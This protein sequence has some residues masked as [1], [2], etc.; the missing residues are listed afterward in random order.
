M[1]KLS[2]TD[3]RRILRL[4][5]P[6]W[7]ILSLATLALFFGAAISLIYPQV[8]RITVDGFFERFGDVNMSLL[9]LAAITIF[10]TQAF[11]TAMR[12]F[13][14]TIVGDRIVT[15]LR[16]QLYE[17]ILNQEIGFFDSAQIGELTS[18]LNSDTQVLQNAV[19]SN[20]SMAL[21]FG[22]QVIAGVT[23]LFW[24]APK[25]AAVMIIAVPIVVFS[26]VY[27]GQKV[28][29]L[30]KVVQTRLAEATAIADESIGGIRTVRSFDREKQEIDRYGNAIELSFQ[31]AKQRAKLRALFSGSMSFLGYATVGIILWYGAVLVFN[32]E[33]TPG[34]LTAFVLYTLMIA[35]AL[36][37]LTSLWSDFMRAVGSAERVFE[38]IDRPNTMPSSPTPSTHPIDGKIKF[39]N[40]SFAYPTR[41][42]LNALKTASFEIQRGEKIALIG[43]SGSGKST[44]ANLILR[45][46]DPQ[47]GKLLID[48]INLPDFDIHHL[49]SAIGI[50]AQEPI[51][52]SGTIH[53]NV[54]YGRI[55]ATEHQIRDALKDANALNFVEE[56]P[57]GLMTT[58]GE[59]GIRLSGGQKQRIAIARAILKDPRILILD[60][61]TSALDIESESLVQEALER[62][63]KNRT[64][65]IIAHR[66]ST[67]AIADRIIV[68][69]NGEVKELGTHQELINDKGAYYDLI[70]RYNL[71]GEI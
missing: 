66:L 17:S 69:A 48:G 44:I 60:E 49:R 31:T 25:L 56:F 9:I 34:E 7:K 59:R 67:I 53:D 57:E 41:P 38:L 12:Y 10:L 11:F 5:I 71:F 42:K 22:L 15:D 54:L 46:Y 2:S 4:A 13:L 16:K 28:R 21:R 68:L 50:V 36:G 24:S 27:F 52:F 26:A 64:T 58:I 37:T 23:I 33:M 1:K 40:I 35:V 19:T 30:S 32:D 47:D 65:V 51:L 6:H 45:F 55:D 63:M 8:A 14:F 29:K 20:L 43:P 61:A 70:R 39:E 3:L 62:L 18:R